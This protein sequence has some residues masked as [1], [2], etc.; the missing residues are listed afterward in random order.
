M[1]HRTVSEVAALARVSVRT[2]HHYDK[3]GLL[4]P[5]ERSEAGYR[6]YD[7][8]D[9]V[10]LHEVL[11]W[12]ALGFPLDEV[13]A[14]LDDAGHDRL[15]A[16]FLHRE[17]L[18]AEVGALHERLAALDEAIRKTRAA[19]PLADVDFRAL[20]DGFD[21]TAFEAEAE[22]AWGDTPAWEES[23]RRTRRYGEAEWRAIREEQSAVN[24]RLAEVMTSGA[25]PDSAEAREAA[26]AHRAHLD[27]WFYTVTD[28][29][30]LG[31]AE[32]YVDDARFRATYDKVA[33]GLATFLRDAIRALHTPRPRRL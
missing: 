25:A 10:R 7:D 20:F 6:L 27:R 17:R 9:L 5:S 33:P 19:E 32:L 29:I 31:L 13:R 22:A 8:A 4:R 24:A 28:E 3:I 11:T 1:A 21:P 15:E 18:V 30:H 23:K 16:L 12:R 14:L 2:L 26:D